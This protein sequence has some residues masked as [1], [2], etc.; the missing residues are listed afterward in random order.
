MADRTLPPRRRRPQP[1]PATPPI[2][3]ITLAMGLVTAVSFGGFLV[4][5][6]TAGLASAVG[7]P[8]FVSVES[9]RKTVQHLEGGI[10]AEIAVRNGDMVHRGDPLIVL[11]S[12][13]PRADLSILEAAHIRLRATRLRLEAEM[14]DAA[15]LQFPADLVALA[16][17]DE[18]RQILRNEQA[19]FA[20]RRGEMQNSI[21]ILEQRIRELEEQSSAAAA[22]QA[23][24]SD[25][26]RFIMEEL[27]G[28][29][30]LY[31]KGYASKTKVLALERAAAALQ[32]QAGSWAAKIA[33]AKESAA[34]T[35]LEI[36]GLLNTRR[37]V[38][39]DE[40]RV[41]QADLDRVVEQLAATR[42]VLGRTIIRAPEDGVVQNLRIHTVGGV[43]PPGGQ[44]MD[45]VPQRDR[46]LMDVKVR[47]EDIDVVHVG[48]RAE[49]YLVPY[50]SR[51][52]PPVGGTVTYVSADALMDEATRQAYYAARVELNAEALSALDPSVALHPGMPVVSM[53][54]LA[55][56]TAL[57][58]FLSPF[59]RLGEFGL[60]EE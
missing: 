49:T 26:L 58:Y 38:A 8:G 30:E 36:K 9:H 60:R 12:V 21:A 44:V 16:G 22:Q 48:Q 19:A 41:V 27:A 56:R 3:R 13:R 35:R 15:E 43:L 50:E 45:L 25:Q 29:R 24:V 54:I 40:M 55:E 11:E 28:T 1:L 47:P 31:S 23:S 10:V 57:D 42:D 20:A 14:T 7:A 32:G 2:A 39:S 5:A 51:R 52:I 17:S 34:K 37:T 33:E 59:W 18:T 46:L 53:I 4:W 6:A